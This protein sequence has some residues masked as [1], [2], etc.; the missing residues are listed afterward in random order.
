MG[1]VILF[2]SFSIRLLS[3]VVLVSPLVRAASNN[4]NFCGPLSFRALLAVTKALSGNVK[5][6][7]VDGLAPFDDLAAGLGEVAAAVFFFDAA[8]FLGVPGT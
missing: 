2:H 3:T 8:L 4:V 7:L 5:S 1:A 6:N